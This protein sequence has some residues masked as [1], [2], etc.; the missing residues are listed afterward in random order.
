MN[1]SLALMEFLNNRRLGDTSFSVGNICGRLTVSDY[2]KPLVITFS[3]AGETV[4]H[5]QWEQNNDN[6]WGYGYIRGMGLNVLSFSCLGK[7]NWYRESVFHNFLEKLSEDLQCFP[8]RLGYGGSMGAYAVSAFSNCLKIDRL[9]LLNPVSSLNKEL[10]PFEKRF[11][12]AQD[13]DWESRFNDGAETN[14]NG[15]VIYDPIFDL[16]AKHAKRY[17]DLS[18]YCLPGVGHQMPIHLKELKMLK[19]CFEYFYNNRSLDDFFYKKIRARRSY[20]RYYKWMLSGA[21]K[22]LTPQRRKVIQKYHRAHLAKKND[23]LIVS[24]ADVRFLLEQ[25]IYL[26][27]NSLYRNSFSLLDVLK[28]IVPNGEAINKYHSLCLKKL[29][30][31]NEF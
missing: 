19:L 31:I 7:A 20:D 2:D 21:N 29:E 10:V 24:R 18:H 12:V 22:H 14:S 3:N 30:D 15:I 27:D 11:R 28:R 25:A 26:Y 6:I 13:L 9:L 16:D 17:K 23:N 4:S 8:A 1:K 5:K